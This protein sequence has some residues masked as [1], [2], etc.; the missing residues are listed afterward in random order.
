LLPPDFLEF[1][2][3][4]ERRNIVA[5]LE[6]VVSTLANGQELTNRWNYVVLGGSSPIVPS[7]SNAL[8]TALGYRSWNPAE[9]VYTHNGQSNFANAYRNFINN[10]YRV[11][12]VVVADLY[13]VFDFDTYAPEPDAEGIGKRGVSDVVNLTTNAAPTWQSVGFITNRTRQ[14]IRAGQKRISGLVEADYQNFGRLSTAAL[15]SFISDLALQM[16]AILDLGGGWL[17]FPAVLSR[18]KYAVLD[19][20]GEPTGRFAYRPYASEAEQ[21]ANAMYPVTWKAKP[22]TRSQVS[23]QTGRGR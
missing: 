17:A 10:Q 13:N 18:E 5:I 8:I 23:R 16:S 3:V 19:A 20:S 14:D 22:F 21:L 7:A 12:S 9:N 2:Y 15:G 6:L 1:E 11:V 4:T